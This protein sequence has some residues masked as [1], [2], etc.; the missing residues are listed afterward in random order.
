MPMTFVGGLVAIRVTNIRIRAF[1]WR[2]YFFCVLRVVSQGVHLRTSA[3]LVAKVLSPN[4]CT[5]GIP[6]RDAARL[7]DPVCVCEAC[8]CVGASV[9]RSGTWFESAPVGPRLRQEVAGACRSVPRGVRTE[10]AFGVPRSALPPGIRLPPTA[11]KLLF[12]TD[13]LSR[14]L[15]RYFPLDG[16]L[17]SRRESLETDLSFYWSAFWQIRPLPPGSSFLYHHRPACHSPWRPGVAAAGSPDF[18][19][20][21]ATD[22]AFATDFVIGGFR[23]PTANRISHCNEGHWCRW[24]HPP[25]HR[26]STGPTPACH[27]TRSGAV[28]QQQL[29]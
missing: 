23:A 15:L 14:V 26:A 27:R 6:F 8:F 13:P 18:V 20:D 21:F 10:R 29:C 9:C 12:G 16:L 17:A 25:G 3:L 24:F 11:N 7:A 1:F 4:D 2:N 22:S 5:V 28:Q 19:T